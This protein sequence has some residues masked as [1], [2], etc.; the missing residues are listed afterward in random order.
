MYFNPIHSFPPTLPRSDLSSLHTRLCVLF[1]F[2]T[3]KVQFVLLTYSWICGP[4]NIVNLPGT[5]SLKKTDFPS[6]N[7]CQLPIAPHL[8]VR[9]HAHL[10]SLHWDFIWLEFAQVFCMMLQTSY[11]LE[12]LFPCCTHLSPLTLK[13]LSALPSAMISE[14]WVRGVWQKCPT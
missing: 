6:P 11:V 10:P 1:N 12:T 3:H 9:L 8:G 2:S 7:S 5:T 14:P 13:N 4:L